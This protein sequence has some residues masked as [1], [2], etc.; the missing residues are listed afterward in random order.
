MSVY[1]FT[2]GTLRRRGRIEALAGARLAE[3]RPGV[4]YGY[5][6]YDTE[7]GYPAVLPEEGAQVHGLVWEVDPG[8][9]ADIDHYEGAD[10]DPPLYFRRE[11]PVR[12][13]GAEVQ[14][15]VYVGNAGAFTSLRP[16]AD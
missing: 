3:P 2:Y 5:R 16:A 12:V 8:A 10:H 15:F 13:D 9:L 11:L 4:L 1:L 6:K 14:A 7:H